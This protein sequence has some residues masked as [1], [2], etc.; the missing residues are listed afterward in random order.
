MRK[1]RKLV[2][3]VLA[4]SKLSS[5]SATIFTALHQWLQELEWVL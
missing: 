3:A 4:A 2:S 5:N 1:T